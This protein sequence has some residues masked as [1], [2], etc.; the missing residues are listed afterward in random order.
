[1]KQESIAGGG[2]TAELAIASTEAEDSGTYFCQASN[3]FGREQQMVQLLV[4]GKR[5]IMPE[6]SL[7]KRSLF[8]YSTG[9]FHFRVFCHS[10]SFSLYF[11]AF[12]GL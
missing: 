1:M 8:S 10:L 7:L 4:Q 6:R 3:L 2:V 11:P 9:F 5:L 12:F